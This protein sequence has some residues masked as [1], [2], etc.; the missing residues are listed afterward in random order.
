MPSLRDLGAAWAARPPDYNR[1]VWALVLALDR[2]P[3]PWGEEIL[4]RCFVARA[5]V[6][7]TRLRRALA[8]ASSQPAAR[9]GG[10]WRL[11]RSLCSYHGRFVARSALVGIRDPETLRRHISV[12]GEEHLAAAGGG[13]ILLGFHLGPR[14]SHLVL[15]AVGHDVTWVGGQGA[16]GAWSRRVRDE[17]LRHRGD[18][19]FSRGEQPWLRRLYRARALLRDGGAIFISADGSG[20]EAFSVP[21]PGG[22]LLV[23][24]GWLTL[25]RATRATVLPVLSHLEGRTQV[26][27]IH[28]ALP[29]PAGDPGLDREACRRA[30]ASVLGEYVRRFPAQCYS[31]A[32]GAPAH[33]RLPAERRDSP[34]VKPASLG[35]APAP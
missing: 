33:A 21:L 11:A 5:F 15:R 12:R 9:G 24:S 29:P 30:L 13:V 17:Y 4:A 3:W 16:S 22:P 35:G 14:G 32:F 23:Q 34:P 25:R 18:L 26:V 31:L 10:R 27:T 28:P 19:L 8:W 6:R 20:R 1:V 2:L 7:V